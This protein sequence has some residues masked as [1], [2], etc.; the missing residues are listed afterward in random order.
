MKVQ[1]MLS[2]KGS[3]REV[4]NQFI[5]TDETTGVKTFQSYTTKIAEY[6]TGYEGR[7]LVVY[8]EWDCSNTTRNYFA[9]FVNEETVFSYE[10]KKEF[11]KMAKED[12]RIIFK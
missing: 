8:P 4:P 3:G 1:N 12:N 7:E 5:I 9:K 11:L 10:S 6:Q 2:V